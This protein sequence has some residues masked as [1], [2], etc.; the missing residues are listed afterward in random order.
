MHNCI[1]CVK[2]RK[3][4]K[5]SLLNIYPYGTI[6]QKEGEIMFCENC[7]Y[8]LSNQSG[9][10]CVNC[11]A[12]TNLIM[13]TY[14]AP[15]NAKSFA[16]GKNFLF[17]TG[18]INIILC[19]FAIILSVFM[20]FTIDWWIAHFPAPVRSW[21]I[22]YVLM[23]LLLVYDLIVSIVAVAKCK[24][25]SK[26][27]LILSLIIAYLVLTTAF[28]FVLIPML[29]LMSALALPAIIFSYLFNCAIY[30]LF[31]VGAIKNI[32]AFKKSTQRD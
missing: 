28:S 5:F 10:F 27:N 8:N 18:I 15:A 25:I 30:A 17:V 23:I 20:L 2:R 12:K 14:N 11:G 16:P 4:I 29:N 21:Q 26:G 7:G 32:N 13:A 19:A 6:I 3:I 1:L 31:L 22:Y 9:D 24:D